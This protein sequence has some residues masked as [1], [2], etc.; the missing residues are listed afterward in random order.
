MRAIHSLVAAMVLLLLSVAPGEARRGHTV[1]SRASDS[2]VMTETAAGPIRVAA[3]LADAFKGLIA[4]FVE[5]GYK[6][7]RVHCWAP[8]GTHVA[9]SNHYL[10]AACDFNQ[11]GWGKTDSFM[12]TAKA[13]E[14]IH[15]WHF[16]NGGAFADWG[17]VDAV[18]GTLANYGLVNYA[19]G[20]SPVRQAAA[21]SQVRQARH[22]SKT[23]SASQTR[24][25]RADVAAAPRHHRH[26]RHRR[27]TA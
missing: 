20:K 16:R 11:T 22:V 13:S 24:V 27:A 12:Y 25:K 9:H 19:S 26:H 21:K 14:L 1:V 15:K 2:V 18:G 17:H 7:T 6:P 8:V 23:R 4:D 5:A 10:G 3:H